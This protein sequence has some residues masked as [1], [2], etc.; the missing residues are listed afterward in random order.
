MLESNHLTKTYCGAYAKQTH[1]LHKVWAIENS[2]HDRLCA[3]CRFFSGVHLF[4][5]KKEKKVDLRIC[6][7]TVEICK[8][9]VKL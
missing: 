7:F 6:E 8:R 2:D 1:Y 9:M 5:C 3:Q 4:P